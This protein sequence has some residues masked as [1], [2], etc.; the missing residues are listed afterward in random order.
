MVEGGRLESVCTVRYRGFESLLLRQN[1]TKVPAFSRDLLYFLASE[2]QCRNG[3]I[4]GTAFLRSV[5]QRLDF[6][7]VDL[8]RSHSARS[9]SFWSRESS[10]RNSDRGGIHAY[11][12]RGL[13]SEP[14][15][16]CPVRAFISRT[17]ALRLRQS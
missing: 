13:S 16:L 9:A 1:P 15:I 8:P 11:S 17:G 7:I 12:G 10:N 2:R 6:V 5:E 3:T 4:L 14:R